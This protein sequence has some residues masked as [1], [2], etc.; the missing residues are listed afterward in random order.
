MMSENQGLSSHPLIG[1]SSTFTETQE[2]TVSYILWSSLYLETDTHMQNFLYQIS[3]NKN[4]LSQFILTTEL[5]RKLCSSYKY[6]GIN[7]QD[8]L[9]WDV[10]VD[11]LLNKAMKRFYHVRCLKYSHADI[12][13]ICLF[14]NAVI[15]WVFAYSASTW[16]GACSVQ[17]R[18]NIKNSIIEH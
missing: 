11:Y 3:G 7:V 8:N 12:N 16:Y 5:Q 2:I 4:L 1:I 9:K 18:D 13:I 14:Y 6:L 10:H 17:L 15:F